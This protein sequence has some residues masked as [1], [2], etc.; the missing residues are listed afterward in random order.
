MA[1]NMVNEYN[2]TQEKGKLQLDVENLTL[3]KKY[4]KEKTSNVE[5]PHKDSR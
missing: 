1:T 4:R 5:Y 2:L 3:Y